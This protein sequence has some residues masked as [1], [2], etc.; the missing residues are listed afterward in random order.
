MSD[1]NNIF[2]LIYE[3]KIIWSGQLRYV[4]VFN[5]PAGNVTADK[6]EWFFNTIDPLPFSGNWTL[7]TWGGVSIALDLEEDVILLTL[8][9]SQYIKHIIDRKVSNNGGIIFSG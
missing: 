6:T 8:V 9:A 5:Y 7:T 3:N 2:P 1:I 4:V